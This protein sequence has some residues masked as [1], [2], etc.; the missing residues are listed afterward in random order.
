[1]IL[2]LLK[3]RTALQPLVWEAA[4]EKDSATAVIRWGTVGG[5]LQEIRH[6]AS[7]G[8]QGRS[9]HEQ[10][11]NEVKAIAKRKRD[12]DGYVDANAA[13][14]E[15]AT[16]AVRVQEAPAAD[17]RPPQPMLAQ[18]YN[19]GLSFKGLTLHAQPKMD[20]LRCLADVRTGKLWS[21]S[22]HE[23]VGLEHIEKA[24]VA[25]C[26][27]LP[28]N[29][30]RFVDGEIFA[31]GMDFQTI[32]SLARRVKNPHAQASELKLVLFDAV[33]PQGSFAARWD[34]L[35]AL[36]INAEVGLV[37]TQ[38][39]ADGAPEVVDALLQ[40]Q[41]K[42]GFEGLMVRASSEDAESLYRPGA[43]SRH[44]LKVKAF[45]Q[46]EYAVVRA[47]R[48][49]ETDTLGS[50]TLAL[51]GEGGA[52]FNAA[53]ATTAES[54]LE[55]WTNRAEYESGRWVATVRFHE[56]TR[57]GVPRFPRIVGFRHRDD[58]G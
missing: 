35:Q 20:G 39:M 21:R 23:I 1:M 48:H 34:W 44:L 10:V 14:S 54:K 50:V 38:P 2:R 3:P 9:A 22:R 32:S 11:I 56:L 43:R 46:E 25:A 6:S 26:A 5:K 57:D 8:K 40:A 49:R 27:P 33:V 17:A 19:A 15:P 45:A 30:T 47:N 51:H 42:L 29:G 37:D 52:T 53:P 58:V 18:V 4:L 31:P 24:V 55:M 7:E 12:R 36:A 28:S 13:S 41:L 16:D